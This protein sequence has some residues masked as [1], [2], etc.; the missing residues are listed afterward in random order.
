[1][2]A[3]QPPAAGEQSLVFALRKSAWIE[4]RDGD[5]RLVVSKTF[6]AGTEQTISG[7]PPL[8]IRIG[9]A[10]DVSLRYKGKPVDLAPHIRANIARLTL[11]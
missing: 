10:D 9:N 11:R 2:S 3:T 7:T 4:V 8:A 6:P 1:M 5:G